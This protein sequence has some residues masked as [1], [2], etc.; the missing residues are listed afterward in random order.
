MEVVAVAQQPMRIT[1]T[2]SGTLEAPRTVHV[3]SER[4]GR[5]LALPFFEGDRVTQGAE[6][7]RLDDALIR[8]ELD[9]ALA[10]RKQAEVDLKRDAFCPGCRGLTADPGRSGVSDSR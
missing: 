6:L 8:A 4:A 2:L 1:R 3:Y 7:M 5:I 9:M 10:S